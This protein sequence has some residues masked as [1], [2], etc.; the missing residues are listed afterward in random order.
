MIKSEQIRGARAILG[1]KQKDLAIKAGISTTTLNNIERGVQTD[2]KISTLRAIR[3]A[4]EAEGVRFIDERDDVEFG[5]VLQKNKNENETNTLLIIDDSKADRTLYKALLS[6]KLKG[7]WKIIEAQNAEEGY[8]FFSSLNPD[9]VLL[10]FMMY[11]AN[12]FQLLIQIKEEKLKIPPIIFVTAFP[13][14][15]EEHTSELQSH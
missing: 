7:H 5:I 14:R 8:K 2:P 13:S 9:C 3:D 6:K 12:G 11:G 15:S 4:L 1:L 10:D